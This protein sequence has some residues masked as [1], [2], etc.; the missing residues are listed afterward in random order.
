MQM[1]ERSRA[2]FA[3]ALVLCAA[4]ARAEPPSLGPAGGSFVVLA[5]TRVMD[6]GGSK[7][8]GNAGTSPGN[9]VDLPDAAVSLGT[10]HRDDDLARQ[11]QRDTGAA[12]DDLAKRQCTNVVTALSGTLAPGVY[13]F[14][15]DARLSGTLTLNGDADAV[16]IFKVGRALTTDDASV[17]LLDGGALSGNVF[18]QVGDTATLGAK[19]AFI[20]SILARNGITMKNGVTMS[21]RAL[22]QSG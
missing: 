3:S 16:W 4:A 10:I 17:I 2:F 8:T 12:Y 1:S 7:L 19:S 14:P 9:I 11:A 5:G 18:W 21:G 22:T 15:A 20:G 6:A 13:C